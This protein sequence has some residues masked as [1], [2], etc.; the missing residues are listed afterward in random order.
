VALRLALDH[1][2]R[3]DGVILAGGVLK[4]YFSFV[5]GRH[6]ALSLADSTC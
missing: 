6:S 5:P 2:D 4:S 3:V 1:P